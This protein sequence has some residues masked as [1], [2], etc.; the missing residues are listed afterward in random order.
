[1]STTESA[2]KPKQL[3]HFKQCRRILR[4][5]NAPSWSE[6]A[7]IGRKRRVI[8]TKSTFVRLRLSVAAFARKRR[9]A[10]FDNLARDW[11]FGEGEK[12]E[13]EEEK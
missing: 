8:H 5:P 11:L 6:N 9:D 2:T 3:K 7:A 1:M 10:R 12:K 13:E 4:R